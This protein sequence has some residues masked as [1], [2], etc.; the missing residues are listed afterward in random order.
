V[1]LIDANEFPKISDTVLFELPTSNEDGAFL[2]NPYKVDNVKIFYVQR[3]F[4]SHNLQQFDKKVYDTEQEEAAVAAEILAAETPTVENIKSAVDLRTESESNSITSPFYFDEAKPIAIFGNPK[5]PAWLS[6]DLDNVQIE[7]VP[8]DADGNAQSGRFKLE[9]QPIG[10]REGDYFICWTW[11]MLPAGTTLS[12]NFHFNLS[13]D[14]QL[15]TSIPSHFTVP[16]KYDDLLERYTPEM[17]KISLSPGDLSVQTID[18]L[19]K[20][21][22]KGFS[23]VEDFAN[24]LV[25]LQDANS[26][27]ESLLPLLSN[28]FNLK[29]KTTDPTLWR[30]Q[31]KNAIR[32]FK[33]KGT[34]GG[35]EEALKQAGVTLT[36]LTHLWQIISKYTWE[37]SFVV[38]GPPLTEGFELEKVALAVDQDNFGLWLRYEGLE[39]YVELTSDYVVFD[40][41]GGVTTMTWV[42]DTLSTGAISL[43]YGDIL[44]VRY[45]YI[46]VPNPTQQTIEDYTIALPLMDQRDETDQKYP[47]KNWN[48]HVIEEDDPLF[49]VLIPVRHP[50]HDLLVWGQIRTEFPYSEN[51]YNMEEYNGSI[52]DSLNP[53]DIDREFVDPCAACRSSMY[54]IVL[55]IENL[56][57]DKLIE[58]QDVLREFS[59][60]HALLHSL[61]FVGGVNEFIQPPVETIEMLVLYKGTESVVAG[62]AQMYFN[63]AIKRGKTTAAILR[64]E[65]AT[66]EVAVATTTGIA[67][68]KFLTVFAPDLRFDEIGLDGDGT[69]ILENLT[70]TVETT[71]SSPDGHTAIVGDTL[72]PLDEAAFTFR[73]SNP[74]LDGTLC[75]IFQDDIKKLSDVAQNYGLLGVQTDFDVEHGDATAPWK[76]YIPAY[77]ATPYTIQNL[78]P[79]GS[80]ILNDP[81]GTLPTINTTGLTYTIR[82]NLDVDVVTTSTGA[83]GVTRRGRVQ[84]LSATVLDIDAIIDIEDHYFI[85]ST[86][87][88]KIVGF[89]KNTNDEFYISSYALGD[90][91]GENLKVYK[92]LA[93][94]QIGYYSYRG[95]RLTKSG[96]DY[97]TDLLISNGGNPPTED[98]VLENNRFKENFLVKIDD[99][100]FSIAEIDG[101]D[102]NGSTTIV[103]NG[104]E[105]YWRTWTK[106]GT[107]VSF[108]IYRYVK[109]AT[110]I[111]GQQ[112]DFPERDFDF[113]DRRGT[114][115]VTNTVETAITMMATSLPNGNEVNEYVYQEE[116]VSYSIEW[117]DGTEEQG[118][119]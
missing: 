20:S 89:V 43:D 59:P 67:W 9:W 54:N 98:N 38:D 69:T 48:V 51:V 94:N 41:V 13:G 8:L 117:A 65:L 102:P 92:R 113:I 35:L 104:P 49:D 63:R 26:T 30:R 71:L 93:D 84:A 95:L 68:N 57:N 96:E 72:E 12:R 75:D 6:T 115:L 21:I 73:V 66:S 45:K 114:E 15:T 79:D 70:D 31:I 87:Q 90:K 64:D 17:Y 86:T 14:T 24:Q 80:L 108:T 25:D 40:T 81:S 109:E 88:Y 105:N 74:V 33:K 42:G 4:T 62:E 97:E 2:V 46:E 116:A 34:M 61:T 29:L 82:T 11:S 77:D 39:E 1:A 107:S 101:N 60:F 50:Y 83:L 85:D 100:Y 10:Q 52:R 55:E 78:L 32:L 16:E 18:N 58:A 7:N 44:R 118:E 106:G 76:A 28:L 27:H 110:T 47:P 103:L 19:N 91:A 99:D 111:A 37:E 112:F 119:I 3:S 56:S 22:A 5:F 23:F 36:K 53:C